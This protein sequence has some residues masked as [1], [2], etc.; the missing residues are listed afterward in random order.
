MPCVPA[1]ARRGAATAGQR[2]DCPSLA[3]PAAGE[4]RE[5]RARQETGGSR[6]LSAKTFQVTPVS[7][8]GVNPPVAGGDGLGARFAL[9]AAAEIGRAS[10]RLDE[11][12]PR[13]RPLRVDGRQWPAVPLSRRETAGEACEPPAGAGHIAPSAPAPR[14]GPL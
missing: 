11:P 9:A 8:R 10:T 6:Q 3:A 13:G 4:A 1:A 5:S 2:R 14:A 7:R 12:P